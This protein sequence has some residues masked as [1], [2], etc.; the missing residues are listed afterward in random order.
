MSGVPS[1]FS[2]G[3][4]GDFVVDFPPRF[5][6]LAAD[7]PVDIPGLASFLVLSV[8]VLSAFDL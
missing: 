5:P 2:L 3:A 6:P 1:A 8:T 7:L 4:V